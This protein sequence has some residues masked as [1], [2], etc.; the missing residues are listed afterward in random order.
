MASTTSIRRPSLKLGTH[1]TIGCTKILL[2]PGW[3]AGRDYSVR[4]QAGQREHFEKESLT[5]R[6][7]FLYTVKTFTILTALIE[8]S[9]RSAQVEKV[10]PQA[11]SPRCEYC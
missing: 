2:G 7:Q 6:R 10:G 3:Q 1:S 5:L 8:K 4:Y 9:K 11:E